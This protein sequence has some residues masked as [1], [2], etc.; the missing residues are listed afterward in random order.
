MKS[1]ILIPSA[2]LVAFLAISCNTE[3]DNQSPVIE[4]LSV[5]PQ[6]ESALICG[7]METNNVISLN[8]NDSLKLSLKLSDNK[9]LSQLKI[10]IHENFDCHGHKAVSPWQVLNLIDLSGTEQL[11]NLSIPVPATASAGVYHFQIRLLDESGNEAGGTQAYSIR[12][13]NS[14]DTIAPSATINLPIADTISLTRGDILSFQVQAEDN[15]DLSSG[16]AELIYFTESGNKIKAD[17][18]TFEPGLGAIRIFNLEYQMPTTLTRGSYEFFVRVFD[19]Y[20]NSF[21][22]ASKLVQLN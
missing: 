9:G 22:T 20:G 18:Y 8:S 19:A 21:D 7:E 1:K 11:L 16:R 6:L 12:L 10:D 2:I 14:A 17:T 13:L 3:S 15:N 4:L 5:S